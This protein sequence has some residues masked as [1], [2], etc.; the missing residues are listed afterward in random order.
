[1]IS[2]QSIVTRIESILDAEGSDR[3]TFEQDYRPAINSSVEWLQAVF[4]R[5]FA[6]KKLSE[7]SLRDLIRSVIYQTNAYSRVR[8]DDPNLGYSIWSIL[9][10]NPKPVVY[11]AN[12]TVNT[13]PNDY[14]SAFRA[15]V[16]YIKSEYSAKRL[17]TEQWEESNTNIFEAGNTTFLNK[18]Q[19]FAYLNPQNYTSSSYQTGGAEIEVRPEIPNEFV[20]VTVLKYPTPVNLITDNVEFPETL[21]NLVVQKALNFISMK[22][23]D[24]T[25][26]YAVSTRDVTTLVQLMV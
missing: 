24:Q 4:N 3:Y 11:P 13:L 25:N 18:F 5:A 1:M 6:D 20:G 21:L 17:T 2:V 14:S 9:K 26:L 8:L 7:E 22:Q 10:V 23:G 16:S 12:A 15:D 19:K